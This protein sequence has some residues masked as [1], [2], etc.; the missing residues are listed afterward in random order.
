[1]KY[2]LHPAVQ[3]LARLAL[4]GVFIYA[5]ID[6]I[7]HPADFARA[8]ANYKVLTSPVLINLVG[9]ILPWCELL[10]GVLLIARVW[11]KGAWTVLTG[12]TGFFIV[13]IV[14]TMIRGIDI[15]CGCFSTTASSKVGWELLIRDILLLIPAALAFLGL[16]R[17][18]AVERTSDPVPVATEAH[19]S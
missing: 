5:S 10:A 19:Q 11:I 6:K 9:V 4:G 14:V 15:N 16:Q 8:V 18:R 13:L 12:L 7:L 1:M 17:S 3:F 2:L